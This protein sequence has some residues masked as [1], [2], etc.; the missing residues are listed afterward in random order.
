MVKKSSLRIKRRAGASKK[1]GW[2]ENVDLG[3]GREEEGTKVSSSIGRTLLVLGV[4]ARRDFSSSGD[5][6]RKEGG[7]LLLP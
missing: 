3:M 4:A 2:G 5:R 1:G 7:D 6:R